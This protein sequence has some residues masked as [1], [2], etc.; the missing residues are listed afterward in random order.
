MAKP[1]RGD[2]EA[3]KLQPAFVQL[4][5]AAAAGW[6][7]SHPSLCLCRLYSPGQRKYDGPGTGPV[8]TPD[9]QHRLPAAALRQSLSRRSPTAPFAQG[10]RLCCSA[11]N[12]LFCDS[13]PG[14]QSGPYRRGRS[15]RA[16]QRIQP[17]RVWPWR[18]ATAPLVQRGDSMAKPCRGD[19]EA[20]KLQ[21]A[22]VQLP[23]A[24][25]AGWPR[26]H[27]SLCLCRLYSPGQRKYDG[28]GTGP[29]RTPDRQHRLPAAVLR[30]SLSR[31]SPTAPFAQGRSGGR[32][33][34]LSLP[35]LVVLAW[36]KRV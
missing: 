27:P 21:P 35:W 32:T 25:A 6:P 11:H 34:I 12:R 23:S 17:G 16:K 7:R 24:A 13:L 14:L 4:P 8:R 20:R 1:C 9:R 28:P 15:T 5:S 10:S 22:F 30:Q 18:L 26:S 3:R 2:C 33:A 19:C 29:V 31:R 36:A